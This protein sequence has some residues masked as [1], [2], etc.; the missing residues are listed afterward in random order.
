MSFIDFLFPK[1]SLDGREGE[2]ITHGELRKLQSCPLILRK[3]RLEKRSIYHLDRL[4]AVSSY[5]ACPLLHIAI[6][7]LKYRRLTA[8]SHELQK[9]FVRDVQRYFPLRV[10]AC[11]C[12][13]PLHWLRLF[14]RGFNQAEVLGKPL[15]EAMGLAF[16]PLLRR[17]RPTG[18]QSLRKKNARW[19]AVRGAFGVNKRI[20]LRCAQKYSCVYLVDDLFTTGATM[21]ECAKALKK[22]G[23][24]RV[25]GIVLAYG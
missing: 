17:T 16:L 19:Q 24:Q 13:V 2:W 4:F 22:N 1:H 25:E 3:D 23:V 21:E 15:A 14:H 20:T 12:P 9:L 5:G 8:V 7:R 11:I 18:H 6:H 10:D